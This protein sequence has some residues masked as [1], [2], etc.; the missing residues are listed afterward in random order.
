MSDQLR[1]YLEF[2]RPWNDI[3]H[4]VV[5]HT[6]TDTR[7]DGIPTVDGRKRQAKIGV[8]DVD[9]AIAVIRMNESRGE[10]VWFSAQKFSVS[11]VALAAQW[12]NRVMTFKKPNRDAR[13]VLEIYNFHCDIDVKP[14]TYADLQSAVEAVLGFCDGLEFPPPSMCVCSGNGLHCYWRLEEGLNPQAWLPIAQALRNAMQQNG[15]KADHGVTIDSARIL[16][17]AGI[18]NF[19]D[20]A[21]PKPT[22]IL[23]GSSMQVYPL[24]WITAPLQAYMG[25]QLATV[26]GKVV[27]PLARQSNGLNQNL[28]AGVGQ[29]LP[30]DLRDIAKSCAV[31][32]DE[33]D[34]HGASA[35][36]PLWSLIATASVFDLTPEQT[37]IDMSD[38]YPSYDPIKARAKL[39][40]KE[41]RQ[42]AGTL[43]WPSCDAFHNA[44]LHT[45]AKCIGCPHFAA[46]KSPLNLTSRPAP[47]PGQFPG[48]DPSLPSEYWQAID[49][50]IWGTVTD[51]KGGKHAVCILEH[52]IRDGFIDALTGELVF[53]WVERGTKC[54]TLHSTRPKGADIR[55]E[56]RAQGMATYEEHAARIG[57]FFMAWTTHLRTT[58]KYNVCDS[59]GWD[60][61]GG[62][63]H[64]DVR[65][66]KTG[67]G[68]AN[69]SKNG[70]K[71]S[72]KF[73][74]KGA[75]DHW[76]FLRDLVINSPNVGQQAILA[77]CFGAPLVYL[78]GFSSTLFSPYSPGTGTGKTMALRTG[79]AIWGKPTQVCFGTTD[80]ANGI[81]GRMAVVPNFPAIW[82]EVSPDE[83]TEAAMVGMAFQLGQGRDK[84]RM[85]ADTTEN[86]GTGFKTLFITATNR[87]VSE[88]VAT[89]NARSGAGMAR[90]FEI[91][92][93]RKIDTHGL[94]PSDIDPSVQWLDDNYGHAGVVYAEYLVRNAS[95]IKAMMKGLSTKIE[96][97]FGNV[98]GE[99]FWR[100]AMATI[101]G[102]AMAAR[103]AGLANFDIGALSAY[104]SLSYKNLK[105][106][107]EEQVAELSNPDNMKDLLL[108]LERSGRILF[109]QNIHQGGGHPVNVT[110]QAGMAAQDLARLVDIWGQRSQTPNV[111]RVQL[112][113][114]KDWLRKESGNG[115][116]GV[117]KRLRDDFGALKV[118]ATIASGIQH[119]PHG[120]SQAWCLDIDMDKFP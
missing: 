48:E 45:A 104:L 86:E 110:M 100:E 64:G 101:L 106:Q 117:L 34:T 27:S 74:V 55:G 118:K 1:E 105:V 42:Q 29:S 6:F 70:L 90:A 114:F 39:A 33:F 96:D 88:L 53:T 9:A 28:M 120:R 2:V 95:A 12:R 21:N 54:T 111:F 22:Y 107:A 71:V 57:K 61:A 59:M 20:P 113:P 92:V 52:V 23:P 44:D 30:V 119:W 68:R 11:P 8:L 87:S 98:E 112:A 80:T 37:F 32:F 83:K 58:G 60:G 4:K 16:R 41:A 14:D 103:A 18:T 47:A 77:A 91:E 51:S 67:H 65:Y 19:K 25:P 26:A 85:N 15:L 78:A 40:D 73:G 31:I 116:T 94:A 3:D 82:D 97:S 115:A 69:L 89:A 43:G 46:R 50:T 5:S 35:S 93:P 66:T 10:E 49:G 84:L 17:P 36:E 7:P 72:Q 38:G 24:A 62:F 63:V 76:N 102:G 99:R 13:T 75:P 109:T 79:A 81:K 56:L 108:K